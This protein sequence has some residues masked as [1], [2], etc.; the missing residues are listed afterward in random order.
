MTG[1]HN[2]PNSRIAEDTLPG[3]GCFFFFIASS[4]PLQFLPF[5]PFCFFVIFHPSSFFLFL[6]NF[7]PLPFVTFYPIFFITHFPLC[8]LL[9]FSISRDRAHNYFSWVPL[10]DLKNRSTSGILLG[11]VMFENKRTVFHNHHILR[12]PS[13]NS[14]GFHL[15]TSWINFQNGFWLWKLSHPHNTRTISAPFL[16]KMTHA[17]IV[18]F[19][20]FIRK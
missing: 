6:T 18:R 8:S 4:F 12:G 7:F 13:S 14:T 20:K 10:L 15:S 16:E 17:F 3:F 19:F 11:L 1:F 9:F 2:F 5:L